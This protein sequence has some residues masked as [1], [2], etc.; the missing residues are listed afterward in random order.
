MSTNQAETEAW[1]ERWYRDKG[2]LRNDLLR[3]PEVLFQ[4]L[5]SQASLI[6]AIRSTSLDLSNLRVL[7]VGCG[8]GS[9]TLL[10]QL[11]LSHPSQLTGIDI[12][13]TR[14]TQAEATFP[15]AN[16]TC[17]DAAEMTYATASFDLTIESTMFIAITNQQVA[18]RIAS[19][20]IRVTKP[21]G[22]I[23]LSDWR[24]APLGS[25]FYSAVTPSRVRQLFGVP[26]RCG[27]HWVSRG[28]LIPP[29]GRF[30]SRWVP[31]MYF[32]CGGLC[33]LLSGQVVVV[34]RRT[35]G[36]PNLT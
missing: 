27:V 23:L 26:Q 11:G 4:Q 10:L 29:I 3:N 14:I 2:L 30:L 35:E 24:Y 12:Q 31:A 28:A 25:R 33:P 16:W 8:G 9:L 21:G 17:G 7:D 13:S 19:E 34:L 18:T 32:L 5:A 22:F 36:Q 20:M 6:R 15:S 1:Y